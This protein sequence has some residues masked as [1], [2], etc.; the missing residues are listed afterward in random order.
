MYV[1]ETKIGQPKLSIVRRLQ[2]ELIYGAHLTALISPALVLTIQ[3]LL[4]LNVNYIHLIIAYLTTLIVYYFNYNKEVNDDFVSNPDKATYLQDR[5]KYYK[6]ILTLY[7]VLLCIFTSLVFDV[8]FV[9]FVAILLAGGI[10]YTIM[11]KVLTKILPGFKN[12]YTTMIWAYAVTFYISYYYSLSMNILVAIIFF[13]IFLKMFVNVAFFDIKDI[14]SDRIN[15]L[16]TLPILIGKNNTIRLLTL[17]N[18]LHVCLILYAIYIQVFP[19]LAASLILFFLYTQYYLSKG[20]TTDS[21]KLLSYTYLMADAEFI[22]WP[23]I[24]IIVK[25]TYSLL[26]AS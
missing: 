18:I 14:T 19:V 3:I 17:L 22:L 16:K 6:Y 10:L 1:P 9:I 7:F 2:N 11:F 25:I 13:L 12:I 8:A 5:R 4:D 21:K 24:L 23:V 26:L 15:N 20:E